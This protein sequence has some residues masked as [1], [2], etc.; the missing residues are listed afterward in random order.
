M[1]SYPAP[2]S[3]TGY[4]IHG[5]EAV[6]QTPHTVKTLQGEGIEAIRALLAEMDGETAA[7]D[8]VDHVPGATVEYIELLY[9]NTL[10]YDGRAIP[11]ELKDMGCRRLLESVLPSIPQGRHHELPDLLESLSVAV[12]GNREAI[13]PVISRLRAVGVSVDGSA[14]EQPDV[15]WLSELLER[16]GSW[17]EA[18]ERWAASESTL[19][20]TR[21][22]ERGWR[23]GPVLS[24]D[25]P[26]CLNCVYRRVDANKAGGQLFTETVGDQPPYARAYV[27]TVTELLFGALLGEVPRYLNEQFVVYDH[28]DQTVETPRVFALPHCEVCNV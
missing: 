4:G 10:A 21:L 11:T 26:A 17:T 8:L 14:T 19:V 15:I 5:G 16:S 23:L 27:D 24:A 1:D 28:Y 13:S 3:P 20:K 18:N 6:V 2:Y 22:T 7:S 9:E 12:L 25:A